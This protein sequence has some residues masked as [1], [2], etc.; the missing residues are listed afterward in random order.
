MHIHAN[1]GI[2]SSFSLVLRIC[3]LVSQV[4]AYR[5]KYHVLDCHEDRPTGCDEHQVFNIL[6]NGSSPE[7]HIAKLRKFT[8]YSFSI[9]VVNSKGKGNFSHNINVTTD[10]DSKYEIL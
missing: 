5:V 1:N 3:I 7:I 8:N 4:I 10:E 9:Q 6:S 2:R